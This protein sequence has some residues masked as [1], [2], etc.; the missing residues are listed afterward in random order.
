MDYGEATLAQNKNFDP[1]KPETIVVI[2]LG[3]T[4]RHTG[5]R[6]MSRCRRTRRA[7]QCSRRRPSRPRAVHP[8]ALDATPPRYPHVQGGS[9]M[10]RTARFTTVAR[11]ERGAGDCSFSGGKLGLP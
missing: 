2:D 5:Q 8:S 4:T 10:F 1:I 3:N 6:N 11:R 7:V 9:I